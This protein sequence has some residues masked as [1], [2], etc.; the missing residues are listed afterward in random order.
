MLDRE[1]TFAQPEIVNLLK[2]EFVPVAIDQAYQRRQKD[3]EGDYY[4]KI[5]GQGPRSNFNS[6]TQGFYIATGSGT[7][8]LYNNNRDP[9][10]VLGLMKRKLAEFEKLPATKA[11]SIDASQVDEK[12]NP[13]LPV[14]GLVV[15]V[16][17]KVLDGYKPTTDAWQAIFQSAMSRDNLWISKSENAALA[18]GEV[19]AALQQRI[20]RYHLVDNTRG[21][22]PM[23]NEKE[24]RN[25]EMKIT[26]GKITGSVH[27]ET[28]D[29][30]RGYEADLL[31]VVESKAGK[32]VRL[33]MVAHGNFWGSGT[34]T[35]TPPPGKFPLA[36]SFT[37]ADGSD[38]ADNIPPQASRG[39]IRGY[40][41]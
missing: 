31:G 19:P 34:Y 41:R 4:R 5:A 8:L 1:S 15:R 33:D 3:A 14:G 40:M 11:P 18:G 30:K 25:I 7:L 2:T 10:K 20:A 9:E 35:G 37:I 13:K 28:A 17:A 29:G 38:V 39:W 27:L 22:P 6:T 21:E 23:W 26:D 16:H 32:V 36:I 12:W 24:I